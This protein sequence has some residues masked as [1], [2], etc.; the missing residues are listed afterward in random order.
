MI[1]TTLQVAL[2][3]ALGAALR[4]L[5]G[6]G[7]LRLTGPG[8]PY[9]ILSVN[10]LGSFLMGL[11]VVYAAQRGMT[12]LSPFVMT[13]ILGGFTTFSAFS[14][15]AYTL[16]ERGQTGG[17]GMYVLASVV[18]SIAGL[19]AGVMIARGVFA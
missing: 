18:L 2:G 13:G 12:H 9:A 15:E 4:F 14:L 16:F 6:L 7:V 5:A 17:A 3:G 8:F 11:F 10:I 1:W 19:I